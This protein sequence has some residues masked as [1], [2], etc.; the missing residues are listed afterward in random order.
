MRLR[1]F[2][3]PAVCVS[4]RRPPHTSTRPTGAV[5]VTDPR[6]PVRAPCLL[7]P[8]P[9]ARAP[10][11][12]ALPSPHPCF[13][14]ARPAPACGSRSC[15]RDGWCREL[16]AGD[17]AVAPVGLDHGVRVVVLCRS[18]QS[19]ILES[20]RDARSRFRPLT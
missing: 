15:G 5:P 9:V 1:P 16:N 4:A 12:D 14:S 3:I 2:A 18:Q 11:A 10:P 13:V 7:C 6:L 19:V 17:D 8:H 20:Y